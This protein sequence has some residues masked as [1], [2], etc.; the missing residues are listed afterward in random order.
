M[1]TRFTP[2]FISLVT[3]IFVLPPFT[4]NMSRASGDLNGPDPV[5]VEKCNEFTF[6]AS[7]SKVIDGSSVA[8]SWD[9]GDGTKS[10]DKI[11]NHTYRRPGDYVV[12]LSV[13]DYPGQ[14]ETTVTATRVVRASIPPT[15]SFV[16]QDTACAGDPL[17]FD[18]AS[19]SSPADGLLHYFWDFGDGT[20]K[21][22]GPAVQKSYTTGG[23]YTVY[24]TVD[25][26]T[27][28]HCSARTAEKTVHVNAAPKAEAGNDLLLKC[29]ET[30]DDLLIQFDASQSAD[31]NQDP[32]NYLWDFGDGHKGEGKRVIHRYQDIGS[33]EV[34]LVVSDNTGLRCSTDVDFT[35][36]RMSRAQIAQAGSD[37]SACLRET[38]SFD[39]SDSFIPKKET[40]LARWSFGDGDVKNGL[41]VKH[42]YDRS[43]TY[44]ATLELENKLN[45]NCP[46]SR[47]TRKVTVNSAPFVSIKSPESQCAG[48][49][50]SFDASAS[51]DPDGD[52]LDYFWNFG[53][54]ATA[55]GGPIVRHT[56]DPGGS[57]RVSLVVDDR[58]GS[59]CSTVTAF[60][61]LIINTP[62]EADA[63]RGV[64]AFA[65]K[66]AAFSA[67][68]SSDI[69][70][71]ELSF[72]W[73]FGDGNKGDGE[74]VSHVY[75]AGGSYTVTLA[76]DDNSLTSC[77]RATDRVTV[78]VKE[79]SQPVITI[80]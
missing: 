73:D 79:T 13:T 30:E 27:Q 75:A 18:A 41:A 68:K 67:V 55:R 10:P 16:S 52:P 76:V 77:S 51:G 3:T 6:D 70:G 20:T 53:D 47:D 1:K 28:G 22:S 54:G 24:L 35:S 11:V 7:R 42:R 29:V 2:I 61:N 19:S 65:G 45:N 78:D 74:Q 9:L 62:P 39:G 49:E 43:G 14:D 64:T 57:Y 37:V 63:G 44:E 72:T 33:Y 32:L 66:A 56:F 71:N 38:V 15:A 40:V 12:R 21:Q 8:Y 25:D 80:R 50:V 58:K 36:V 48:K 69:D 59:P 46:I 23:E 17:F 26:G 31:A 4:T 60:A 5:T 34:A